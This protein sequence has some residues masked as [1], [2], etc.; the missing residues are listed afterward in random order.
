MTVV[1]ETPKSRS[2]TATV[3]HKTVAHD[4]LT[5]I[6]LKSGAVEATV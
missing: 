2:N 4:I 3:T 5:V 6:D 1:T